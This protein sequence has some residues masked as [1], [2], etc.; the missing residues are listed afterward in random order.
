MKAIDAR[1]KYFE[2]YVAFEHSLRGLCRRLYK[3]IGAS[4]ST[5]NKSLGDIVDFLRNTNS[6]KDYGIPVRKIRAQIKN[7]NWLAHSPKSLRAGQNQLIQMS[8]IAK[9]NFQLDTLVSK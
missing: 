1:K 9:L 7:R 4:S 3:V 6:V 8:E 2:D 5:K